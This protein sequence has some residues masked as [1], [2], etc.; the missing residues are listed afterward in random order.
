MLNAFRNHIEKNFPELF[1]NTFLLA[2][3]GG[4]D[5]MVLT[6]LCDKCGLDFSLA[7]CNFQLRGADSNRDEAL[8][9]KIAEKID[10]PIFVT[11]FNT[12]RYIKKY[13][14]SVQISARR[15][16]YGWFAE[17]MEEYGIANLVTA[18][19][20]DDNLET[21]LINLSRGT[22][23]E[24]LTGIPEKRTGILRPLLAFPREEIEAYA[25]SRKI[26]W[27]E[28][29]SNA[30]TRYLRNQI[31]HDIVPALKKLNPDFL[32][33][34]ERTRTYLAQTAAIADNQISE[35][36]A[37][38]FQERGAGNGLNQGVAKENASRRRFRT[39]IG[40][41]TKKQGKLFTNVNSSFANGEILTKN[42]ASGPVP[43]TVIK[44]PIKALAYLKPLK[45]YLYGLF[46]EYGFSEWGNVEDLLAAVSGKEVRS[47]THR[48]IK[49]RDY[50]LLTELKP[51]V[52]ETHHIEADTSL[53]ERPFRMQIQEVAGITETG[54]DILYVPK[55]ALKYPL[56][57]RKWERGDY[58]YPFGMKGKKKISK[59]FKDAKLDAVAKEN[60]WLLCS[61]GKIVWVVG[62]RSD[63]RFKIIENKGKIL[64]FKIMDDKP[65]SGPAD[66]SLQD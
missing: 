15:L 64:Q 19:H 59:F 21:F 52:R 63:S 7:H 45:G 43:G 35:L 53:I 23:I 41:T 29:A 58:F 62:K 4:V 18:H 17:I 11:N 61:G 47:K 56:R 49:G 55:N 2:C 25:R 22:G 48:L 24:G 33:N 10:K 8:V 16:R 31:R 60:Q 30:D 20:A 6:D 51:R 65:K 5:S 1:A 44:I 42:E 38:L 28:D 66:S 3:S 34:F 37:F 32:D 54:S 12:K 14:V 40:T 27:R 26:E 9:E 36:K 39:E 50:L 46:H 13:K 57:L